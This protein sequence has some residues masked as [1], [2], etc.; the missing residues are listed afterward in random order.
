[1][2]RQIIIL[3]V[4]CGLYGCA[5][6][7]NSLAPYR[8]MDNY[9]DNINALNNR[10]RP[11]LIEVPAICN[12][13]GEHF[14]DS[15]N[16]IQGVSSLSISTKKSSKE[17]YDLWRKLAECEKSY[18]L[19]LT[20]SKEITSDIEKYFN[21]TYNK[22]WSASLWKGGRS[23][24]ERQEQDFIRDYMARLKQQYPAQMKN[25]ELAQQYHFSLSNAEQKIWNHFSDLDQAAFLKR[26]KGK[27]VC[28]QNVGSFI[29]EYTHGS[30]SDKCIY[31]NEG[32]YWM[33]SGAHSSNASGTLF[34]GISG[35]LRWD[36]RMY[37][38]IFVFKNT[39]KDTPYVSGEHLRGSHY[40]Y[41]GVYTYHTVL[42]N[43]NSVHSFKEF[44]WKQATEGLYFYG[45]RR[46]R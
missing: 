27:N 26:A 37:N 10:V 19:V 38:L 40:V 14:T 24:R 25:I 30:P 1:M 5:G 3:A 28:Q 9:K 29:S 21:Y 22:L 42:G 7:S 33:A 18:Q 11:R 8:N 43:M 4:V 39:F 46:E 16:A 35:E 45:K 31:P 17:A 34:G 15:E 6:L 36:L 32:V 13:L 12:S 23:S 20:N 44:D 2:F 41:T